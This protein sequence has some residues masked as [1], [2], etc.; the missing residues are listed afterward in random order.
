MGRRNGE[1]AVLHRLAFFPNVRRE[2]SG[3]QRVRIMLDR[4]SRWMVNRMTAGT[5]GNKISTGEFLQKARQWLLEFFEGVE[6]DSKTLRVHRRIKTVELELET[7]P[8]EIDPREEEAFDRLAAETPQRRIRGLKLLA[9]LGDADLFD[10]CMMFINDESTDVVVAAL[11]T[12]LRC[13]VG[14]SEVL[15]PL[16]EFEDKRVRAAAIAALAKHSGDDAPHWFERGLKDREACVRLET[17]VILSQLDPTEHRD[18]FEL[19]RY[20]PNP[21]VKRLAQKIT[22]GKGFHEMR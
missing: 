10:W 13:D 22:D 16:A 4:L 2:L 15:E 14:H 7:P 1:Q 6:I 8:E 21:E 19:A 12:A 20:D 17:V 3:S 5:G 9:E 11:Q 18:V